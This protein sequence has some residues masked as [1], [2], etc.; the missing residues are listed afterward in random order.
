MWHTRCNSVGKPEG[1]GQLIRPKHRE[2]DNIKMDLKQLDGK[3]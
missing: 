1:N 2:Q 3:E